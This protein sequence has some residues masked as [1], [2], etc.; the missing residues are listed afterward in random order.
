[1]KKK[2]VFLSLVMFGLFFSAC[3]EVVESEKIVPETNNIVVDK[4]AQVP[5]GIVRYCWEE[6]M[7]QFEPNGPGLT[8]DGYW[9]QP[10]YVAVRKVRQGKWRPCK[11]VPSEVKGETKNER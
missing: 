10:S 9:Y 1:M 8:A 11:P 5:P 2:F 4:A 3:S 7:V 6:P